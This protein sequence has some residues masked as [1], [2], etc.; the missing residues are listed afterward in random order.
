MM[1]ELDKDIHENAELSASEVDLAIRLMGYVPQSVFLPCVGTGRHIPRLLEHGVERI[2][3]VDVSPKNF[4]HAQHLV[5]GSDGVDIILADL[6]A[7]ESSERFDAVLLLGNS[8]GDLLDLKELRRF[9]ASITRP[10]RTHGT[11]VMDYIG[12]NYLAECENAQTKVWDVAIRGIPALDS[13]IPRYDRNT[14]VMII[15]VFVTRKDTTTLHPASPRVLWRGCY[16]KKVLNNREVTE[17]FDGLGDSHTRDTRVALRLAGDAASLNPYY[18]SMPM[19]K[20]GMLAKS[21]WWV[22]EAVATDHLYSFLW[23]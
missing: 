9:S 12:T 5:K 20:F 17:L 22:G 10:L 3:G 16:K 2:V 14:G 7:W 6:R 8:F 1:V 21:T 18:A 23:R 15:D 11:F 19:D 4:R 13:R